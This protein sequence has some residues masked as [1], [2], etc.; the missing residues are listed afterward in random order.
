MVGWMCIFVCNALT[1]RQA[2]SDPT[3]GSCRVNNKHIKLIFPQ[4]NG[5]AGV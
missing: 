2:A 1:R 4:R 5:N 3:R